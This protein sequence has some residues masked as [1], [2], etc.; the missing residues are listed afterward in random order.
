MAHISLGGS[1]RQSESAPSWLAR[2][3]SA[4]GTGMRLSR[5]SC[6]SRT[7]RRLMGL[8]KSSAQTR[9]ETPLATWGHRRSDE[10]DEG[11]AIAHVM[12]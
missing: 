5:M 7:L 8:M 9:P 4:L 2:C 1:P 6:C 10:G 12:M 3:N 11:W